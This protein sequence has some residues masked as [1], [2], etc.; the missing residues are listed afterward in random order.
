MVLPFFAPDVL[1]ATCGGAVKAIFIFLREYLV[2]N[3]IVE[4][5]LKEW[6]THGEANRKCLGCDICLFHFSNY[7]KTIDY[8]Q[9]T[10]EIV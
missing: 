3:L 1:A 8:R 5:P 9:Q 2:A 6:S 4:G 7:L 10:T